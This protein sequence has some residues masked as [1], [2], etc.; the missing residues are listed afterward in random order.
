MQSLVMQM[1]NDYDAFKRLWE[2]FKHKDLR[3]T[4][5]MDIFKSAAWVKKELAN[6][7]KHRG[8]TIEG[9]SYIQLDQI[10]MDVNLKLDRIKAFMCN[11]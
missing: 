8:H 1:V 6:L 11:N 5:I 7:K 3:D 4:D 2:K 9:L 10:E